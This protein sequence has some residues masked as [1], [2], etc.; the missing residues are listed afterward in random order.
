MAI[1]KQGILGGISGR[2]GNVVGSSWKGIP[3]LKTRPLSV[4][5]PRTNA[6][7]EQRDK[8][9]TMVK[10]GSEALNGFVRPLWDRFA[11]QMS[12][13]NAFISANIQS[14]NASAEIVPA[15]FRASRG[16]MLATPI[17]YAATDSKGLELDINWDNNILDS[18]QASTDI[19]Y[20]LVVSASGDV[21]VA[22]N[23][24]GT[25]ANTTAVLESLPGKTV[26]A[27][28]IVFLSF[29][30]VDGTVVSNSSFAIVTVE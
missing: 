15:T 2:V 22:N 14:L 26:V 6:Q 5:N 23:A 24:V 18:F 12:G 3:V 11:S 19:P 30:R 8:M 27:G 4:A 7:V 16:R 1:L 9:S 20:I 28:D 25:R 13:Y 17:S 29:R 21:K 10:I